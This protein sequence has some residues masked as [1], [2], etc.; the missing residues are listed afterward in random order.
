MGLPKGR[1]NNPAGRI[2]GSKNKATIEIREQLSEFLTNNFPAFEQACK[3]LPEK[4]FVNVFRDL[5]KYAVPIPQITEPKKPEGGNSS[6]LEF[7]SKQIAGYV[8]DVED[9]EFENDKW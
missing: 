1:T 3:K 2:P 5:L 9:E 4:D 7:L 8:L 6:P